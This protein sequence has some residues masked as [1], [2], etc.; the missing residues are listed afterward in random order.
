MSPKLGNLLTDPPYNKI[1]VK[2][3][4]L[5]LNLNLA[6]INSLNSLIL[7]L[8]AAKT[9]LANFDALKLAHEVN[10]EGER[11]IGVV[12]KIDL[13]DEGIGA[14]DLLQGRGFNIYL[15]ILYYFGVKC[16]SQK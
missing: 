11:T 15:L 4:L 14:L 2:I 3:I 5:G 6:Y 9:D 7:A 8:T 12:A 10:P 13:L 1:I 16:R